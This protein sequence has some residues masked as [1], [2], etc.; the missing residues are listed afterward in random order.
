MLTAP[1]GLGGA[2]WN[3][4]DGALVYYRSQDGG[5]TWD[6]KDMQLPTLDTSKY[7]GF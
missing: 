2:I 4:L 3:G 6:I 7:L 1:T 5:V